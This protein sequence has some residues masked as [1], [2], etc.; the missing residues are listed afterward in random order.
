MKL[1]NLIFLLEIISFCRNLS[2]CTQRH[3]SIQGACSLKSEKLN[4]NIGVKTCTH[5]TEA[6]KKPMC[7]LVQMREE[8]TCA[9]QPSLVCSRPAQFSIPDG[10]GGPLLPGKY[11][12]PVSLSP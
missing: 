2:V 8:Y 6:Q 4:Y 11:T 1:Y 9:G 5:I 10:S 12:L 7:A 3:A